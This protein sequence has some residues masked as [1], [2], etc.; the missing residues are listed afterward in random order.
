MC[1]MSV[2]EELSVRI[3]PSS[4]CN[5]CSDYKPGA[6]DTADKFPHLTVYGVDL[7]PPPEIWVPPNCIL[8]V[9]DLTCAW[10]WNH[11]WDLVH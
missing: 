9:D 7:S 11:K 5:L 1:W 4:C 6:L 8:E 2:Q 10:T 3:F